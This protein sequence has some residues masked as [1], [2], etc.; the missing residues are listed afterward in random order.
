MRNSAGYP[1]IDARFVINLRPSCS[2]NQAHYFFDLQTIMQTRL[3]FQRIAAGLNGEGNGARWQEDFTRHAE[4]G[5]KSSRKGKERVS[6]GSE[7]GRKERNGSKS[8]DR[9]VPTADVEDG[10]VT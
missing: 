7:S 2:W 4:E 8:K 6:L 9:V 3:Y 5:T 1:S 10:I